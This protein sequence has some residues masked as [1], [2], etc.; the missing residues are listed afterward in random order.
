MEFLGTK[1]I[2]KIKLFSL[3]FAAL[4]VIVLCACTNNE[5]LLVG[6]WRGKI[7]VGSSGDFYMTFN[8]DG[9]YTESTERGIK[10]QGT[11]TLS[12]STITINNKEGI[13]LTY[14]IEEL[15]KDKLIMASPVFNMK[16][17]MEKVEDGNSSVST[18][19]ST[20]PIFG[21]IIAIALL[22]IIILYFSKKKTKNQISHSVVEKE[23]ISTVSEQSFKSCPHCGAKLESDSIFCGECGKRLDGAVQVTEPKPIKQETTPI[24]EVENNVIPEEYEEQPSSLKQYLPYIIGGLVVLALIIGYFTWNNSKNEGYSQQIEAVDSLQTDSISTDTELSPEEETQARIQ[25]IEDFYKNL[26]SGDWDAFIRNNVNAHVHRI[27]NQEYDYDCDNDDCLAVWLFTHEAGSDTGE[28]LSRN[29]KAQDIDNYL[30]ENKYE[31]GEYDVLLT[32]VKVDDSYKI[33]DIEKKTVTNTNRE[34]T[35]EADTVSSA[36]VD[37]ESSDC[38]YVYGT[39]KELESMSIISNNSINT[40]SLNKTYFTEIGNDERKEIKLYSKNATV[41]S[42]HPSSSYE[43]GKDANGNY[44]LNIVDP[45]SFWSNTKFLVIVVD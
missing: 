39:K 44:K 24:E 25:Y 29:I 19:D 6:K 1:S 13:A 17:Q 10:N 12:Q 36:Y 26:G 2:K 33:A 15:K 5:S 41:L 30:V 20:I 37:S 9:S 27:L 35:E 3:V 23:P 42:N 8:S 11:W 16:L 18:T 14:T 38:Y 32:L 28:L 4:C 31:Y 22:T 21:V 7:L 40:K 34:E 45:N 43:L